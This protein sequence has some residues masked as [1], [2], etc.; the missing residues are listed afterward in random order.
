MLWKQKNYG[1]FAKFSLYTAE[2]YDIS[3]VTALIAQL[4]EHLICNQ[5]VA[6][7]SRAGGTISFFQIAFAFNHRI[8]RLQHVAFNWLQLN[9]NVHATK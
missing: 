1:L 8:E 4:V 7:S 3:A 2:K 9:D 6:R 5:G